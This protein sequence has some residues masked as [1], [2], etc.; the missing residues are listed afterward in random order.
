MDLEAQKISFPRPLHAGCNVCTLSKR[1]SLIG[2]YTGWL[3]PAAV[4]GVLVFMYGV[5]T[6]NSNTIAMETCD[7][8]ISNHIV[9]LMMN[10]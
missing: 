5:M 10:E 2:F 7:E 9:C 6:M 4:V 8:V 3:L 1:P